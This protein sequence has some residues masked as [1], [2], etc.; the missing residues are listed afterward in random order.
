[1]VGKT[2]KPPIGGEQPQQKSCQKNRAAKLSPMAIFLFLFVDNADIHDITMETEKMT[3]IL[4]E[5][6]ILE[7]LIGMLRRNNLDAAKW[8]IFTDTLEN[9]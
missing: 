6:R 3:M 9:I 8:R 7:S 1:M 4:L 5:I 2:K